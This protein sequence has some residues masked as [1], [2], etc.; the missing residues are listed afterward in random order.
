MGIDEGLVVH[1]LRHDDVGERVHEGEVAAV[2]DLDVQIGD[3]GGLDGARIHYDDLGALLLGLHDAASHNGMGGR[4]IVTEQHDEVGVLQVGN[5]HRHGTGSH[6]VHKPDNAGAVAGA[7]AGAGELLHDEVGLVARAA[8]GA[9]QH[10]SVRAVLLLD[11]G[12]PLRREVKRL[13]PG[14]ALQLATLLAANH[15]MQDARRQD[16]RIVDEIEARQA[17]QAQLALVGHTVDALGANDHSVIDQQVELASGAAVG[18][19]GHVLF[20]SFTPPF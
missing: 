14:D 1:I 7:N 17:L 13:V 16:L 18:T 4:G 20:H 5:G 8:G 2:L 9:S 6:G 3:A 12:Q 10:D 11:L 15:R 19:Y